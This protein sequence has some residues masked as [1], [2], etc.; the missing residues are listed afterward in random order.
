M[1]SFMKEAIKEAEQGIRNKDGGPFGAVIVR[2]GKIIG[3]G[4]NQVIRNQDPTCH[5]EIMAIHDASKTLHSFD[6][7]GADIYTTAFPCPMCLGAI[8][9]A[10]IAHIYYGATPEDTEGI[11]FRDKAFY[12]TMCDGGS[13]KGRFH[14][15]DRD[16]CLKVF[17]EYQKSNKT[18]Y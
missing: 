16:E 5:G 11:G 17:Q 6:L 12:E 10:N 3:R 18:A 4:H 7:S 8:Y 14:V 1:D 15:L 13:T 2:D 9:W